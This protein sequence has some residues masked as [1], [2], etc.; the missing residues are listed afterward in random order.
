[1][2]EKTYQCIACRKIMQDTRPG[3]VMCLSCNCIQ[4]TEDALP[5][6]P[7]LCACG[8]SYQASASLVGKRFACSKCGS[9]VTIKK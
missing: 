3:V 7:V 9:P 8:S 5:P 2:P 1:M 6:I 4:P